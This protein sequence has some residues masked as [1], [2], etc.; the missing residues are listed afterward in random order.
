MF[1]GL[2]KYWYCDDYLRPH[3]IKFLIFRCFHHHHFDAPSWRFHNILHITLLLPLLF[4]WGLYPANSLSYEIVNSSLVLPSSLDGLTYDLYE[5]FLIQF[6]TISKGPLRPQ[7]KDPPATSKG[8]PKA[9]PRTS[10]G[11]PM[12]FQGH[13]KLVILWN[14]M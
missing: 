3:V 7:P 2:L 6:R 10:Q 4:E 5:I 8:P 9:P 12:A 14:P 1:I 11:P 13:P